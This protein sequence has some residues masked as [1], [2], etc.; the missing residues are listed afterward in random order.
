M[1]TEFCEVY[2]EEKNYFYTA[3]IMSN[4][5]DFSEPNNV[6]MPWRGEN[7]FKRITCGSHF[8]NH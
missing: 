1:I 3:F 7:F 6:Q 4:S 5:R 8:P 2:I